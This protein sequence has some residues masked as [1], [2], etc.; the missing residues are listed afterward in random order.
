MLTTTIG[1]RSFSNWISRSCELDIQTLCER[2]CRGA[3]CAPYR[4]SVPLAVE[5]CSPGGV[6]IRAVV[7]AVDLSDT[8]VGMLSA[9]FLHPGATGEVLLATMEGEY[10]TIGGTVESGEYLRDGLHY[11]VFRFDESID[12]R[13]FLETEGDH[14]PTP[15]EPVSSCDL[16]SGIVHA[17]R[18]HDRR[19]ARGDFAAYLVCASSIARGAPSLMREDDFVSPSPACV[20]AMDGTILLVNTGWIARAMAHQHRGEAFVGSNYREVLVAARGNDDAMRALRALDAARNGLET[21][22]RYT[23]VSPKGN[24]THWIAR[25]QTITHE[26]TDAILVRHVPLDTGAEG[27]G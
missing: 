7:R 21:E 5:V 25:Y 15:D 26:G 2:T 19:V 10:V 8:S 24:H 9:T 22:Q 17:M 12:R 11:Q 1:N 14:G 16:L 3:P 27:A 18:G 4:P 23:L 13:L 6:P 20:L